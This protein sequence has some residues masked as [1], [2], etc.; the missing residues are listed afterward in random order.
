MPQG[1]FTDLSD[2]QFAKE[3]LS[4]LVTLLGISTDSSDEQLSNECTVSFLTPSG[5]F[6]DFSTNK[7][8]YYA[9][10]SLRNIRFLKNNL[11]KEKWINFFLG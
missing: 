10:L 3:K 11:P 5:I 4:I 6:I 8:I 1:I 9:N 7:N 2:L